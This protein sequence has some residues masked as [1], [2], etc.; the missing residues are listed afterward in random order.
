M[1]TSKQ[2]T[3]DDQASQLLQAKTIHD[4]VLRNLQNM[5]TPGFKSKYD[6][7]P[8]I[9]CGFKSTLEWSD[10]QI[11]AL[12]GLD[13]MVWDYEKD[14]VEIAKYLNTAFETMTSAS[15]VTTARVAVLMVCAWNMAS[16]NDPTRR[17]FSQLSSLEGKSTS[18]DDLLVN[19]SDEQPRET[20]EA[21]DAALMQR[22]RSVSYLCGSLLR[23]V[24]KE[25]DNIVRA[26]SSICHQYGAFYGEEELC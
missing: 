5:S 9:R 1:S 26:W 24:V 23:M 14:K 20:V 22:A 16:C 4:Q 3:G 25:E 17:L 2:T 13:L 19:E 15:Q 21:E 8:D 7:L 12:E 10:A 6:D 18:L 11:V